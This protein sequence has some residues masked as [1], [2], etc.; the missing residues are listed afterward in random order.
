MTRDGFEFTTDWFDR[1]RPTWDRMLGRLKPKRILEVG[2]FEGRSIC[3]LIGKCAEFHPLEIHCVD[4][5]DG[6]NRYD[7]EAMIAV[8]A[9]FDRNVAHAMKLGRNPVLLHKHK[10]PSSAAL[11]GILAS[12]AAADFDLIYID[13]SHQAPDVLTDAV[14]AFQLLRVGGMMVFDDYLW[15]DEPE[16]RQDSLNMPK[17]AIDAFVNIFQ[18]KLKVHGNAPLYQLYLQKIA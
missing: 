2:S 7:R 13:G 1:Y 15:C 17:P 18:R 16:G 12:R 3:Y 14:L 9:R 5:W 8:E 6:G 11:A 10:K 4:P